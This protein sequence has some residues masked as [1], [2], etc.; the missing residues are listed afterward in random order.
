MAMIRTLTFLSCMI[1]GGIL[2]YDWLKTRG[3][4]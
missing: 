4:L 3:E 1:A 2:A